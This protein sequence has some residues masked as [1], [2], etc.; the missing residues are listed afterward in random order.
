MLTIKD[1]HGQWLGSG[2]IGIGRVWG[3][4]RTPIPSEEEVLTFLQSAIDQ[5]ISYLDTA[6]S[7]GT[8]EERLG[9]FLTTL[10]AETR[11]KLIIATKFGE[12]WN[13]DKNDTYIDH[14]YTALKNSIDISIAHLKQI[15]IL[16]LHKTTP[17]VLKNPDVEKAFAYAKS[18]GIDY[19]GASVSDIESGEYVLNDSLYSVIQLPYNTDNVIFSEII[20]KAKQKGKIVVINRPFN[21]GKNATDSVAAFK[22][23]LQKKCNGFILT[24]TKSPEH[25]KENIEAFSKAKTS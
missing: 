4:V 5:G 18:L 21:M 2:L 20:D 14:S 9:K 7:Y 19:F 10:S 12:Y 16:Y 1:I 8:S 25:L 6:P 17:E 13:T 11:K 23:I 22:F 3:H 24:G 15:N